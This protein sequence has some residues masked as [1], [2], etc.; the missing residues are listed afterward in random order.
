[1]D[2]YA[3]RSTDTISAPVRLRVCGTTYAGDERSPDLPAGA[4]QRVMTGALIPR[5][6]DA[7]CMVE[8]TRE[9]GPDEVEIS[10][11][12][13]AG[14][15]IRDAGTD[16]QAG[17]VCVASGVEVSPAHIGVLVSAGVDTVRVHPRPRVGMLST[18]DELLAAGERL[19]PGKIRDSNL[20]ALLARLAN[21]GF[22][23][24]SLGSVVDETTTI[25]RAI[26]LGAQHCDAV[27]TLG[28]V[29]VGEH[30][31]LADALNKLGA[32]PMASMQ[33][34]MRPAKPFAF[35][36]L[37]DLAVPIFGLPGNPVSAFVSYE[38]IVRP[39][40]RTMAGHR[41][42]DRPLV[43]AIAPEGLARKADGKTHFARVQIRRGEDGTFEARP[44]SRQ[45]SH[46]ML[47]LAEADGLAVVQDGEGIN[48]GGSVD[49]LVLRDDA[50]AP[51]MGV[52]WTP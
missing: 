40:L 26:E 7:V 43:S 9:V 11:R 48:P 28:G 13:S 20:P 37:A 2:G 4:A 32:R 31:Y 52:E 34:A 29:S 19:A 51:G 22:P 49:V 5:G 6:A 23:R 25:A 15:N 3:L 39:A 50:L 44:T 16:V 41:V 14:E 24:V 30:D 18:G 27:I 8:L 1:M 12:V 33:I 47:G 21:D 36:V 42:V 45:G 35:G 38:L 17:E 46:Q 10:V